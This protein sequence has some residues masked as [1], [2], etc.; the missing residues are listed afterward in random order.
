MDKLF[1]ILL[2]GPIV[3]LGS[4]DLWL[5][6][7]ARFNPKYRVDWSPWVGSGEWNEELQ[8]YGDSYDLPLDNRSQN[9]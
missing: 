8:I 4:R 3:V 6:F 2:I 1:L 7:D 5:R 9:D